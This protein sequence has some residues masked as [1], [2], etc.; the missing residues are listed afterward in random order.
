LSATPP[1]QVDSADAEPDVSELAL[2]EQL[3]LWAVRKWLEGVQHLP[4]VR[5]GFLLAG[6]G[7][8]EHDA[9]A[10]FE[11][12]YAAL[13]GNC[14]R[15]LWFH[16]C[17]CGCV[18]PDELAILGL[19]AAQ[20]A[21]DP[22]SAWGHGQS[23]VLDRAFGELLRATRDLAQALTERRLILPLR[24]RVSPDGTAAGSRLH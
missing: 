24:Q 19:I 5:R 22:G 16:R 9:F 2:G 15:D 23:L 8:H 17:G 21:G 7:R 4:M 10:A 12:F 1:I 20:Q 14:R 18:S 13:E 6:P 11:R 3:V